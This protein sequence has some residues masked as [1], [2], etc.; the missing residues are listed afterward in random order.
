MKLLNI[1][2]HDFRNYE[3]LNLTFYDGIHVFHGFNAQGKTNLLEAI[4][5]LS[6]NRSHRSNNDKDL[7]R[8][9]QNAFFIY[10]EVLNKNKIK[11]LKVTV[12]EKGKN[13]FIY[14]NQIHKVSDFIGN[15]NAILFSPDDMNLFHS[16]PK[17]RRKFID[18][19]LSKL[20]K[21][22]TYTL[23]QAYR[24]L[25]E[26]N[27]YLKNEKIDDLFLSVLT[28][29]LIDLQVI[30]MKQRY[31][32]IQSLI[33]QSNGF[34]QTLSHDDSNMNIIYHSCVNY[35]EDVEILKNNL[36]NKYD[37]SL[38]RDKFLKQTTVGIHKE[39]FSFLI[40]QKEVNQYAS[41]GQKRSVLLSLKIAM[42]YLI[43]ELI[44]EYPI[45]LLDDVFSELDQKRRYFLLNSLPK[46]VQ[47]FITTT[48]IQEVLEIK[49]SRKITLFE[50][51][52]GNVVKEELYG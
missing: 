7:I 42:I 22:Y 52:K 24:L 2:L 48:D 30:I 18:I 25:K 1:R 5:Y 35:S 20:S 40:N 13:L 39:D 28:D 6:L 17:V 45:L 8:E 29:Q 32:F 31:H 12:S 23:N 46:A 38:Q 3:D 51:K 14:Q 10:G 27:A 4:Y 43:Y 15:L 19:E 11:Q 21:K 36:K 49:K 9:D 34:Y 26:R 33:K 16:S 41:Q 37:A 50:V 47:I 44:H